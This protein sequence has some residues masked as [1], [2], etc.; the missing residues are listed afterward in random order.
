M[1]GPALHALAHV[2]VERSEGGGNDRSST[3]DAGDVA[4]PILSRDGKNHRD[5]PQT[6][7]GDLTERQKMISPKCLSPF[8]WIRPAG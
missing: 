5:H 3:A 6:N 4:H 8:D 2:S 1:D 7:H